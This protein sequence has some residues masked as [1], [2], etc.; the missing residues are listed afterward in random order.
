M[1]PPLDHVRIRTERDRSFT[2]PL[3]DVVLNDR[4]DVRGWPDAVVTLG[5]LEDYRSV[6][7][8][9]G[10]IE[11]LERP[12]DA[13]REIA[14]ML[15]GFDL[16][17]TSAQRV[18]WWRSGDEVLAEH[19]LRLMLRTEADIVAN[20]AADAR[21][22]LRSISMSTLEWGFEEPEFQELKIDGL[23]AGQPEVR[24]AAAHS[25]SWDEPLAAEPAL[26]S[27]LSDDNPAVA[28][29]GAYALQY[30]PSLA[31]LDVLRALD[32][33]NEA[34][35]EQQRA[36]SE[37]FIVWT[38]ESEL[39]R[40]GN[41]ARRHLQTWCEAISFEP[42]QPAQ[43]ARSERAPAHEEAVLDPVSDPAAFADA[44]DTTSGSFLAK[45]K[46][47][48][49]IVWADIEP[50]QRR[51]IA[52]RLAE[53]EDPEVRIISTV[54]LS[55][56]N[57]PEFLIQ[58][59]EDTHSAVRKGAMYELGRVEPDPRIAEVAREHLANATSTAAS[60]TLTTFA[61][62]AA[63]PEREQLLF[64]LAAVDRRISVRARAVRLLAETDENQRLGR[65]MRL[66]GHPPMVNWSFHLALLAT[67]AAGHA[68]PK[69]LAAVAHAD[70]IHIAAAVSR[71]NE[72]RS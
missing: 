53:H 56:W 27:L 22:P 18:R 36:E 67:N 69:H 54:A 21:H 20:V 45:T 71:A 5:E 12:V 2:L 32:T 23:R 34:E 64:D 68:D 47:L 55:R 41:N 30:Y 13:R 51:G 33:K 14:S 7:P 42:D 3:L 44:L 10:F 11:D 6:T 15:A 17:T 59:L 66:L 52:H 65:L 28:K 24:I 48:R 70:N 19:G 29:A 35:V 57:L 63:H 8:L 31:T 40:C 62:H 16:T 50:A 26:R 25:V 43:A 46:S 49:S 4:N 61:R 72:T 9:T 1:V 60:E 39:A 58:L 38:I 37:A